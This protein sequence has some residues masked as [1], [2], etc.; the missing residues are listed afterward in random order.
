MK[1]GLNSLP[2]SLSLAVLLSGCGA[3]PGPDLSSPSGASYLSAYSGDWVLLRLQSDD[4]EGE[5]REKLGDR[6]GGRGGATGSMPGS[7]GRGGGGTGGGR[8]G[9]MSGGRGGAQ[10][11]PGLEAQ[12]EEMEARRR[13]T[14]LL[15]RTPGEFTLTLRPASVT[16]VQGQDAPIRMDLGADE[17]VVIQREVEFFAGAEWTSEG[18]RI[19][20]L[21]EGSAGVTDKISVDDEGH[22]IVKRKLDTGR[23]KV[24]GVLRYQRAGG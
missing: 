12:A 19:E 5:L 15:A 13:G 20:R 17:I 8:S 6:P 9:G 7:G 23:V 1:T 10:P 4:L 14:Q 3:G 18:L 22:L 11:G 2:I 24:E 21:V 16:F